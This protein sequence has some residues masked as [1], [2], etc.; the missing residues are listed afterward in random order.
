MEKYNFLIKFYLLLAYLIT[1]SF[2]PFLR[3]SSS[4]GAYQTTTSAG[5][6][7]LEEEFTPIAIP[8]L[9]QRKGKKILNFRGGTQTSFND[10]IQ[11]NNAGVGKIKNT[12]NH[13]YA[14]DIFL[15]RLGLSLKQL[16]PYSVKLENVF[17]RNRKEIEI[18]QS[19]LNITF[20]PLSYLCL[21]DSL[22]AAKGKQFYMSETETSSLTQEEWQWGQAYGVSL[23][24]SESF[25][26]KY[27]L[28]NSFYWSF[29][30]TKSNYF[31][32]LMSPVKENLSFFYS[33]PQ[34]QWKITLETEKFQAP[35]KNVY[36]FESNEYTNL[37]SFRDTALS[38]YRLVLEKKWNL[39]SWWQLA[40]KS[41]YYFEPSRIL[42]VLDRHHYTA[43]LILFFPNF[44]VSL[45][46]DQARDF[47]TSSV[48]VSAAAF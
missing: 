23:Q 35:G 24:W 1:L 3:A 37:M 31:N 46:T 27:S 47:W 25:G 8:H 14:I 4:Y 36:S 22:I 28:T 21:S 5:S 6:L 33:W 39:R 2:S 45:A 15:D 18:S 26:F 11:I 13:F 10:E 19:V 30:E 43:G 34:P 41:G 16:T 44:Q 32:S 20:C 17:A 48:S 42:S 40:L 12:N 7:T 9:P 29:N 38:S